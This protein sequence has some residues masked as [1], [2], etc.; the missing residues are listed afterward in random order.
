MLGGFA[1]MKKCTCCGKE[2]ADE[3]TICEIDANPLASSKVAAA[4]LHPTC[5]M[6]WLDKQF[7]NPSGSYPLSISWKF[8]TPMSILGVIACKH[9]TARK[10]AWII[11]GRQMLALGLALII[12]VL[13]KTAGGR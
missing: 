8:V 5:E 10:N 2:Y 6:T 9:P 3:A 4:A 13:L 1:R 7:S 12:L 11:F